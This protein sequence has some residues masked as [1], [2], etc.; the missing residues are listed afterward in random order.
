MLELAKH[1]IRAQHQPWVRFGLYYM[2]AD[3]SNKPIS[4]RALGEYH[5]RGMSE[6]TQCP[7]KNEFELASHITTDGCSATRMLYAVSLLSIRS[8]LLC[9]NI[10]FVPP[11]LLAGAHDKWNVVHLRT[12]F[13]IE[14]GHINDIYQLMYQLDG[15]KGLMASTS[16]RL[17]S[18]Y[19]QLRGKLK[20]GLG[21]M[22][23][24]SSETVILCNL[25]YAYKDFGEVQRAMAATQGA[26]LDTSVATKSFA[27]ARIDIDPAL[28]V[29]L[30]R[31]MYVDNGRIRSVLGSN[32]MLAV[33]WGTRVWLLQ[34]FLTGYLSA[35]D[36]FDRESKC[37]AQPS[38]VRSI[39]RA[40][41]AIPFQPEIPP[42]PGYGKQQSS[43]TPLTLIEQ[44]MFDAQDLMP[45]KPQE[46]ACLFHS[47]IAKVPSL[48]SHR[49]GRWFSRPPLWC[50]CPGHCSGA[51]TL[52]IDWLDM[53]ISAP[54][55]WQTPY[56][57]TALT[58]YDDEVEETLEYRIMPRIP[59]I[60]S[61]NISALK[62]LID[63]KG[64]GE[65]SE[66]SSD[67]GSTAGSP[68]SNLADVH[69]RK[70]TRS[71]LGGLLHRRNH[72]ILVA[73]RGRLYEWH[74]QGNSEAGASNSPTTQVP[75]DI[76]NYFRTRHRI[77]VGGRDTYGDVYFG[78]RTAATKD[79]DGDS[80]YL[81][82]T[83]GLCMSRKAWR[84]SASN[85]PNL[86]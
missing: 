2:L 16:E 53:Q 9:H 25:L 77:T 73:S 50:T 83:V 44:R 11:Y 32:D 81:G 13:M 27:L 33:H 48:K 60:C 12:G 80:I 78:A 37:F 10:S 21:D 47:V 71:R 55:Y 68:Q 62:F 65:I 64:W 4:I 31:R 51:C 67:D 22:I 59:L 86:D 18:A 69:N 6:G 75:R 7:L 34:L 1:R 52:T 3:L 74:V 70:G 72:C 8:M 58:D 57:L 41:C 28:L 63:T 61:T 19:T 66:T 85:A 82:G 35:D 42:S 43:S 38:E 46:R 45:D 39:F 23:C 54:L 5:Q 26:P 36:A 20:G 15:D 56:W 17:E 24:E 84:R 49:D 29:A 40:A 14:N 76:T 30:Y 79:T